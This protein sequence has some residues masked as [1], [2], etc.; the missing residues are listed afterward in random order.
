MMQFCGDVAGQEGDRSMGRALRMNPLLD[1]TRGPTFY[2]WPT[3]VPTRSFDRNSPCGA[4]DGIPWYSWCSCA[5][6]A[7]V[8]D[9][10]AKV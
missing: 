7:S 4:M 5:F 3:V 2:Q 10:F 9:R 6:E 8:N 1:F